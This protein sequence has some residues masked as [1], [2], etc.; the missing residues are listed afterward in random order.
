MTWQR[1]VLAAASAIGLLVTGA[2]VPATSEQ[3]GARDLVRTD[4]GPVRGTVGEDFRTFQGIPY[5]APPLDELRWSSPRPAPRWHE[6]LDATAPRDDCAQT[7]FFA[8]PAS[9]SEDCLYLNV[10][11][12]RRAH[13]RLPVVVWLHAGGYTNGAGAHHDARKLAVEGDVVVVTVNYR[14]GA[15]GFLAHPALN[16]ENPGV[17]SGNYGLEDQR[18]ALRWVRRNVTA[19][20]GDPGNVTLAGASSGSGSVCAHLVSPVAAGLFHRAILQSFACV[21]PPMS[22]KQ[23]AERAGADFV[24][25]LGCTE[26]AQ[27]AACLRSKPVDELVRAWPGGFPVVGG[28]EFPMAPAEA[29][30]TDRFHHVPLLLGTTKDE[31][32]L[33]VGLQW[34]GAGQPVTP[35]R[36]EEIIRTSY[37]A[38]AEEVLRRYPLSAY[39][40]PS[41]ALATVQTDAPGLL[42]TCSHLAGYRLFAARP[43]PVPVY[44][45]QFADRTAPGLFDVPGFDEGAMHATEL[46]FLFPGHF[47]GPLSDQQQ[48]LSTTLVRYWAN[49]AHH[50]APNGPG[51]PDWPRFRSSADVLSLGL[52]PGGINPVDIGT[53][54]NCELWASLSR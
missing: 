54:S 44:A 27:T 31:M 13:G 14:L 22:T 50:G 45:Y 41:I 39:P 32:R 37:G 6:P 35:A 52:G 24:A 4:R 28:R 17:Q 36:Y 5:A 16:E 23:D 25:G 34:D 20:G 42:S 47:G 15:L 26:P 51:L 18:A 19:F 12:P 7:P 3:A 49:F 38:I 40:S 9:D 53:A 30:R 8:W 21:A 1:V 46:N 11:T 48:A 10:T 43:H 29:L 2:A 33:F